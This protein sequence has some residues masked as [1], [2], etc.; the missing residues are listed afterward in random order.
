MT[1]AA[2]KLANTKKELDGLQVNVATLKATMVLKKLSLL[3]VQG[4]IATYNDQEKDFKNEIQDLGQKIKALEKDQQDRIVSENV[5]R[6]QF[7]IIKAQKP[8]A[9]TP[10]L[11]Q[12][13]SNYLNLAGQR[14]ALMAQVLQQLEQRRQLIQQEHD[15]LAGLAPGLKHLESAWKAELLRRPRQAV[16]FW[17]QVA[18]TLKSLAGLPAE[19]WKGLKEVVKSKRLSTFILNH[20]APIIGLFIFIML[21]GWGTRRLN[22]IVNRRFQAWKDSTADLQL[23]PLYIL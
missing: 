23:L 14:D 2:D 20:L 19:G 9:L 3:R 7:N 8:E 4:L 18:Q 11:Q 15:L 17:Q 13:F 10:E 22:K 16:P 6:A 5:L 12:S 21:L 1:E